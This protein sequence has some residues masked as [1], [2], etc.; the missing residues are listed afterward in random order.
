MTHAQP[1]ALSVALPLPLYSSI[2]PAIAMVRHI[3][4]VWRGKFF[5]IYHGHDQGH[6]DGIDKSMVDAMDASI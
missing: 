2:I 5:V 6:H 3:N 1:A 4:T